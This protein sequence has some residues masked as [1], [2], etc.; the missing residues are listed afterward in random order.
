[1]DEADPYLMS[2]ENRGQAWHIPA[3]GFTPMTAGVK[4]RLAGVGLKAAEL[5]HDS[6]VR[7]RDSCLQPS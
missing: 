2:G 4:N 1:M 5:C 3:S 7:E 6:A